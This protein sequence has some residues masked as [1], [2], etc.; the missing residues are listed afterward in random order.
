MSGRYDVIVIGGG[1]AGLAMGW[2]LARQGRDFIVLDA[3]ERIGDVWRSRWD[4]LRLFTPA[5]YDALPGML[6]PAERDWL[7]GKDEVADYLERYAWVFGLPVRSGERV[8][9]VRATDAHGPFEILT[10]R[11]CYEAAQVVIATGPF[12]TPHV[13]PA[14]T[15]LASGIVQ[16]HSSS[17]RNPRQLPDGPVVVVGA[18]NSGVQIAAELAATR[19]TW[20]AV[21]TSLRTLPTRLFGQSLFTWL[22][23]AGLMDVSAQSRL[24]RRMSGR[25]FLIGDAPARVARDLGVR[26]VGRVTG[27]QGRR[28]AT[29]S[30]GSI[31]PAAVIWATGF[32]RD[33][34]FVKLPVFDEDGRPRHRRGVTDVPGVYFLGLPWLHTRGSALLGWV[35][36]DAGYLSARIADRKAAQRGG[37]GPMRAVSVRP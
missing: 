24:G 17:Y 15:T 16:M 27:V 2:H 6:F 28:V 35:G 33:F 20:L 14:A 34:G 23:R 8:L 21:G 29:A 10:T 9:S 4:S 12:Q 36:R 18:A 11:D 7:P 1:Q 22:D 5:R 31:E 32:R 26:L 25:D 13:P 30:E 3:A 37:F 19:P